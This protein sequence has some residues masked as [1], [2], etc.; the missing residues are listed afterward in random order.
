MVSSAQQ[1]KKSLIEDLCANMVT[2]GFRLAS[3]INLRFPDPADID[4]PEF[5][6]IIEDWD[7]DHVSLGLRPSRD[8]HYR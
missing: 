2:G 3:G 5:N 7:G 4:L 1:Q 6:Q 8:G